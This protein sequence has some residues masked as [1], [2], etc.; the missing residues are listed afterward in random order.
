MDERTTV[1]EKHNSLRNDLKVNRDLVTNYPMKIPK[2]PNPCGG[3]FLNFSLSVSPYLN[4]M[5]CR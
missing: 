3:L 2:A 1:R 5:L 4:D